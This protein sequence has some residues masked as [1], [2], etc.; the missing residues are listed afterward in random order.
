MQ[1]PV[2]VTIAG[3]L[4]WLV[5]VGLQLSVI[6]AAAVDVRG[7]RDSRRSGRQARSHTTELIFAVP[8]VALLGILLVFGVDIA[9]RL[10]FDWDRPV[11][12]VLVL[13]GLVATSLIGGSLVVLAFTRGEVID[14]A[15]LRA[16]LVEREGERMSTAQL[17]QFTALL[18][19]ADERQRRIHLGRGNSVALTSIRATLDRLSEEFRAQRPRGLTAVRAIYWRTTNTVLW[20]ASPSQ[21]IAV[22]LSCVPVLAYIATLGS[23]NDWAVWAVVPLLA[24]LP[25]VS[26]FVALSGIRVAIASKVAWHAIAQNQRVEVVDLLSEF[27]RSSRKGVAGLGDRV[28]RA[29]QIL[30]D[31]QT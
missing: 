19:E 6:I 13:F 11:D 22:V 24:V 12:A 28:A 4:L 26:Y 8:V 1:V 18:A 2:I 25:L 10:A 31:Q 20:R 30:R 9:G 17:A 14:Y 5:I 27:E 21:L 7:A 15:A 3:L 23:G 29:L 16:D